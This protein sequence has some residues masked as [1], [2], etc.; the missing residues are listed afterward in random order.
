MHDDD[1]EFQAGLAVQRAYKVWHTNMAGD[2]ERASGRA[3]LTSDWLNA[4]LA[5][6]WDAGHE[7]PEY[8]TNL[9]GDYLGKIGNPYR[10]GES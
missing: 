10:P 6:A 2:A 7:T 5:E 1:R 9:N 3:I 4:Q 8:R